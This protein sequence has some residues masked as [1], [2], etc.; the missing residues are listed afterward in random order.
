MADRN[1]P[2][3]T[4][5]FNQK[6]LKMKKGA[7]H[8]KKNGY[9]N[10]HKY[11]YVTAEDVFKVVN[12]LE[13]E[14]GLISIPTY[15]VIGTGSYQ[16]R[17]GETSF[18]AQVGVTIVL[19][20][21]DSTEEITFRAIGKGVDSDDKDFGKA[22]TDARKEAWSAFLSLSSSPDIEREDSPGSGAKHPKQ[23]DR[24]PARAVETAMPSRTLP[25]GTTATVRKPTSS[26]S[27]KFAPLPADHATCSEH[28]SYIV[29]EG[30]NGAFWTCVMGTSCPNRPP[31]EL[32][33]AV[34]I[35]AQQSASN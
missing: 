26:D 24:P 19:R 28:G 8:V 9:N 12:T 13:T 11:A 10:F 14:L 29:R 20:D 31:K 32:R 4:E 35:S 30:K 21:A 3:T 34:L 5:T 22:C 6:L 16:T 7:S 27:G 2:T 25:S 15:E 17:K 23:E 18:Y 33:N 1:E